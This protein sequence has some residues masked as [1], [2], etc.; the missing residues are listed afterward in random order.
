MRSLSVD[1]ET[2]ELMQWAM[3]QVKKQGKAPNA[4]NAI[5]WLAEG[6]GYVPKAMPEYKQKA[7]E[8]NDTWLLH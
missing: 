7:K 5:L 6:K 2:F 1:E 8:D 4:S 3:A